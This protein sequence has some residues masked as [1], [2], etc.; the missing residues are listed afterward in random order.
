MNYCKK[1]VV[2]FFECLNTE[3]SNLLLEKLEY[4]CLDR[5]FLNDISPSNHT[6]WKIK[7]KSIFEIFN[8]FSPA[9]LDNVVN[10]F[11]E[12]KKA[13]KDSFLSLNANTKNILLEPLG[14]VYKHFLKNKKEVNI[15]S[16]KIK[17]DFTKKYQ[18]GSEDFDFDDLIINFAS[19]ILE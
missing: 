4:R 7:E 14:D 11:L 2:K 6:E 9:D 18:K 3:K 1:H 17:K 19:Y 12:D 10:T 16:N 5:S 8:E 15:V 13:F